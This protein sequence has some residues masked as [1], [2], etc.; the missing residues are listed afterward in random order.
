MSL[1]RWTSLLLRLIPGWQTVALIV[2]GAAIVALVVV[3]AGGNPLQALNAVLEGSVESGYSIAETLIRTCPLLLAGLGVGIAFRAGVWNIGAEGQLYAG[4]LVVT[5]LMRPLGALPAGLAIP[6][7]LGVAFVA[8][9]FWGWIAAVMRTRRNVQEVITT[10]ML[11]F[12]AIL[13]VSWA[14]HGPLMEASGLSPYSDALP[15]SL[16]L[17]L[18]APPTRLHLGVFI[19]LALAGVAWAG[20]FRTLWGFKVRTVGSAPQA[21]QHAGID[22]EKTIWGAIW[23]SGGLAGMA[24]AVELMGVTHRL[25]ENFSPGYGYTAIAVALLGRLNPVGVTLAAVLFG[26]LQAGASGMERDAGVDKV[27][28]YVVQGVIICLVAAQAARALRDRSSGATGVAK[29]SQA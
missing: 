13:M 8:G 28:V 15:S 22:P 2:S 17:P 16:T 18:L 14:V 4:A 20:L 25:F 11:N 12:L 6:L 19:A 10:I 21:A 23:V 3:A 26:A 27:F 9:G 7:A 24:G 5:A 29:G 1:K